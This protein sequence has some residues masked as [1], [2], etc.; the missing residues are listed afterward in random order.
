MRVWGGVGGA[1]RGDSKARG[2]KAV[3]VGGSGWVGRGGE[4]ACGSYRRVGGRSEGE[5]GGMK[6]RSMTHQDVNGRRPRLLGSN[7]WSS[8]G[9]G[10]REELDDDLLEARSPLSFRMSLLDGGR[11]GAKEARGWAA[12]FLGRAPGR[13]DRRRGSRKGEGRVVRHQE[14]VEITEGG[15]ERGVAD[16]G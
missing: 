8:S 12:G 3:T 2:S 10:E 6:S 9:G 13:G 15:D 7:S 4:M 11:R 16:G 1:G 14:K 5:S